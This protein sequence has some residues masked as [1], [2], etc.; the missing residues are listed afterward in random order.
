[1]RVVL[2]GANGQLGSAV[3]LVLSS[4]PGVELRALTHVD[5]ELCDDRAT[6]GLLCEARP[7]LVIN[8]AAYHRV[9]DC[10]DNPVR[11]F[12]VNTY[13][14]LHLAKICRDLDAELVHLSTDYVFAGDKV[15]GYSEDDLP[16]PLNAYGVSKLAGEYFVRHLCPKHFVVR[17]SGLFGIAGSRGKGSNFVELMLRLAQEGR[18]IRVVDDQVLSPTYTVDL[19]RAIVWLVATKRYGFYHISNAGR[20]SWYEFARKIFELSGLSPKLSPTTT[21]AFGARARRP[22]CSV[23]RNTAFEALSGSSLR[24]WPEALAAYLVERASS[25][26]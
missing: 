1:M 26:A 13:A 3:R 8:T 17:S 20:C 21:A 16:N 7:D 23:L 18:D 24:P 11:A 15:G 10:E 22:A 19:A 25:V 12:E 9:D 14:A 4:S 6:R 2:I 5:L